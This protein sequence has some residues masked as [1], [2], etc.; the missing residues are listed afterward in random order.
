MLMTAI[1]FFFRRFQASLVR[2]F[3]SISWSN[4]LIAASFWFFN[5]ANGNSY[6]YEILGSRYE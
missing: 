4:S 6:L 1:L 5:F 3:P 2:L